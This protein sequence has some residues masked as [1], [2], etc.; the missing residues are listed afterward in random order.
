M[1]MCS[2]TK[3][4]FPL[5]ALL[6]IAGQ[7]WGQSSND[8]CQIDFPTDT[9][10]IQCGDTAFLEP[11]DGTS[12]FNEGFNN[13]QLGPDWCANQPVNFNNPCDPS[14]DGTPY[15]WMGPVATQPRELITEQIDV[16]CG[17]QICFDFDMA[18]QSNSAPCEGPDQPGEGVHLQWSIDAGPG[19][20]GTWTDIFYFD[21]EACAGGGY[22]CGGGSGAAYVNWDN[23]CFNVPA[24]AQTDSTRF[25]FYQDAGSGN[26]FD[27]WGID[28]VEIT[29]S[30]CGQINQ[31]SY[32]GANYDTTPDTAFTPTGNTSYTVWA[33]TDSVGS[34]G[35]GDTCSAEVYVDVVGVPDLNV[36]A[37]DSTLGCMDSTQLHANHNTAGNLTYEWSPSY[38]LSDPTVQHPTT[39]TYVDTTYT[40][41]SHPPGSPQCADTSFVPIQNNCSDTC[42]A[43]RPDLYQPTCKGDTDGMIAAEFLGPRPPF[44]VTWLDSNGNVLQQDSPVHEFDTLK[45]IPNGNYTIVSKDTFDCVEDT[46][47]TLGEPDRIKAHASGD[48]TICRDG[49]AELEVYGTGGNTPPYHYDWDQGIADSSWTEASPEEQTSYLVRAYDTAG[50]FSAYDTVPVDLY[51]PIDVE[52]MPDR[53]ICPGA[54]VQLETS[55]AEGGIG[56]GYTYTWT[57]I[58]GDTMGNG[59]HVTVTPETTMD[60]VVNVED[61]CETPAGKDTVR[62][63]HYP[64]PGVEV[65]VSD[66]E[67][68]YPLNVEFSTMESSNMVQST[69]WSFGDGNISNEAEKTQHTFTEP[70][71]YD[72]TVEVTSRDGCVRDSTYED[73]ICVRDYPTAD[74][75][76]EP[77]RANVLDPNLTFIDRSIGGES[78]GW[79][80]EHTDSTLSGPEVEMSFPNK[81]PGE[82]NVE[83]WVE[84]EYGC[85]DSVQQLAII[86]GE[87]SL[88]VPNAFTP[89]SD[90][91]NDV[92]KPQG[93]GIDDGNYSFQVYDRWGQLVFETSSPEEGWDGTKNGEP[94]PEGVYVWKVELKD[95]YKGTGYEKEGHVTLIR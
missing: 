92:F 47:V 62:I 68:C 89:N 35:S 56:Y 50:C 84:N 2:L 30:S 11:L 34:S 25:R 67:G 23:Y 6:F 88:F 74:F 28:N 45:N 93:E 5:L 10:Q 63:D 59:E 29:G 18:E 58:D 94:L 54:S 60:Y 26:D 32:D 61:A 55:Y 79:R 71:C 7:S 69:F 95:A 14:M 73:L 41:I 39:W 85:R 33:T 27:H 72:V 48:T 19:C 81:E 17:G 21:P 22:G 77:E 86:E 51:P 20:N 38:A 80:F 75:S 76:I 1:K 40:V 78:Y 37:D 24:A 43:P 3:K 90:G 46:V 57:N 42:F 4:L 12:Q 52:T 91:Q 15:A 83:H 70:G 87:H 13:Q 66:T 64:D 16:S 9:M 44:K 49:T 53:D 36:T 31:Y 8:S 82:F 65:A